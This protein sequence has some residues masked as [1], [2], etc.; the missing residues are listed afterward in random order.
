MTAVLLVVSLPV[1]AGGLTLLL[2]DR[3]FNTSFYDASGGGDAVLYIHIFWFFGQ[4]WPKQQT[5]S[6]EV[7]DL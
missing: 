2:L 6:G 5:I 7:N 4:M 1:L 3:N